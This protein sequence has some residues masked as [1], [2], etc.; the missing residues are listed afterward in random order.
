M[1]LQETVV[2]KSLGVEIEKIFRI[3]ILFLWDSLPQNS[4]VVETELIESNAYPTP[5]GSQLLRK[6]EGTAQAAVI[7]CSMDSIRQC[8]AFE[9]S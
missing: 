4:Y 1:F 9:P 2:R 3:A 8:L 7:S 5:C 6:K